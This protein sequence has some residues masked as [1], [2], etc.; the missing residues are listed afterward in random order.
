MTSTRTSAFQAGPAFTRADGIAARAG[1][2]ARGYDAVMQ[3]EEDEREIASA[4]A[5][6]GEGIEPGGA[7]S[8]GFGEQSQLCWAC[9]IKRGGSYD[10]RQERWTTKPSTAD[11]KI[12]M[13]DEET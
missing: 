12:R 5:D 8:Y 4:C 2:P 7:R 9:A 10:A 11:L 1:V 13:R 3:D 6:C